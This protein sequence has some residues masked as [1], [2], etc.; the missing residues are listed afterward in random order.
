MPVS[1]GVSRGG[2]S[3]GAAGGRGRGRTGARGRGVAA[4]FVQAASELDEGEE[5]AAN[6]VAASRLRDEG[7]AAAEAGDFVLALR[8]W[9]GAVA[10]KPDDPSLHELRSQ[11]YLASDSFWEAIQAAERA[12]A[13]DPG[14]SAAFL[15]L[16]RA[17]LNFGEFEKAVETFER[18]CTL[19]SSLARDE[20]VEE[21]LA[22]ARQ[23]AA[24]HRIQEAARVEARHAASVAN[25]SGRG[26]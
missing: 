16:G 1:F 8:K 2:V 10:L 3:K 21:D 6:T 7:V 24:G 4:S 20:G 23:L 15:T 5:R 14:C 25:A 18:L 11:C 9:D 26:R 17:Q 22:R 12:I 13:L 19:D